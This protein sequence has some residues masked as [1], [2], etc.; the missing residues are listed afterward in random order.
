MEPVMEQRIRA[1]KRSRRQLLHTPALCE[2]RE[3]DPAEICGSKSGGIQRN[4]RGGRR[5]VDSSQA[6]APPA[7]VPLA[8]L[9][10][11]VEHDLAV[12]CVRT[13]SER[14]TGVDEANPEPVAHAV[15]RTSRLGKKEEQRVIRRD[16]RRLRRCCP[17]DVEQE[18]PQLREGVA[19][20]AN[21][22]LDL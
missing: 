22:L 20:A 4:V 11:E 5:S 13:R 17:V 8:E 21:R 7:L 6:H 9:V 14:R 18:T 10:M 3:A 16:E 15:A 12:G 19:C 2:L 1:G